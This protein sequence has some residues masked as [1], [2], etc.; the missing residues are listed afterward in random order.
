MAR[1]L[2]SHGADVNLHGG[3]DSWTPLFY[4]AMAG[5][6]NSSAVSERK[7]ERVIHFF[8]P[9]LPSPIVSEQVMGM[10]WSSSCLSELTLRYDG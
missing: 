4:A 7:K 2:V 5:E 8:P 9:V 3:S 1:L 10:W 6:G